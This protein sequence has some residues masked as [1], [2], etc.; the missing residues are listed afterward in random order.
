MY[1]WLLFLYF[2]L[3]ECSPL[4]VLHSRVVAVSPPNKITLLLGKVG[5]GGVIGGA[6][7]G[8]GAVG[9]GLHWGANT[10]ID[11]F[12]FFL[13]RQIYWT[14][15]EQSTEDRL[16]IGSKIFETTILKGL[17]PHYRVNIFIYSYKFRRNSFEKC[18]DAEAVKE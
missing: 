10:C 5:E 2:V 15:V 17:R 3:S 9:E 8:V 1:F 11:F 4:G 12:S 7:R 14:T 18:N 6:E 16:L 13:S